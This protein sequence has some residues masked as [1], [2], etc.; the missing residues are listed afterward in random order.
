[1]SARHSRLLG[2]LH[3]HRHGADG[4][5]PRRGCSEQSHAMRLTKSTP[6]YAVF[7]VAGVRERRAEEQ[8]RRCVH[9]RQQRCACSHVAMRSSAKVLACLR[10]SPLYSALHQH[11]QVSARAHCRWAAA[12]L[13]GYLSP[14]RGALAAALPSSQAVRACSRSA[15]LGLSAPLRGFPAV[16]AGWSSPCAF[17]EHRCALPCQY[18]QCSVANRHRHRHGASSRNRV[19]HQALRKRDTDRARVPLSLR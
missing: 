16:G 6:L 5:A 12:P 17:A 15:H 11:R 2:R 13:R 3:E 14:S 18:A 8:V 10:S 7:P 19:A 4:G 1:M 9:S